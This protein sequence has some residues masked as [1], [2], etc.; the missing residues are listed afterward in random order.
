MKIEHILVCKERKFRIHNLCV[1]DS[2]TKGH[3]VH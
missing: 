2:V 1:P 3:A